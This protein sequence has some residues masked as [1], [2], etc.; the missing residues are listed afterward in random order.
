MRRLDGDETCCGFGGTFC[1][2]YPAISNAIVEEK[3]E[4]F[5]ATGADCCSA[6][7]SAA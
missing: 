3:A 1:V 5:E 6:A 4:R 7:I 2:K